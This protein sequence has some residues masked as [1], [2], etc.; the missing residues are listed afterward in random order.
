ML[1]EQAS[2]QPAECGPKQ[3]LESQVQKGGPDVE[4]SGRTQGQLCSRGNALV[5]CERTCSM[6][7]QEGSIQAKESLPVPGSVV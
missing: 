4:T 5:G 1:R 6:P 7:R 2:W 3:G